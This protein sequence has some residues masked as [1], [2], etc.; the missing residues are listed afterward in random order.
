MQWEKANGY[1][2]GDNSLHIPYCLDRNSLLHCSSTK[3]SHQETCAAPQDPIVVAQRAV[4][5]NAQMQ[6]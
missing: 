6:L 1:I 4:T 5:V 3:K 2:D